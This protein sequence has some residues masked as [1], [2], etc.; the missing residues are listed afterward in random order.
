MAHAAAARDAAPQ[1]AAPPPATTP[2]TPDAAPPPSATAAAPGA[3]PSAA[4]PSASPTT[5]APAATPPHA[6]AGTVVRLEI[7]QAI[8]S[9]IA[10]RGDTFTLRL[11]EPLTVS[12]EELIPTGTTGVGEVID[13]GHPGMGGAPAKLVLAARYLDYKG[14]HIRL[15]SFVVGGAG[16]DNTR[17]SAAVSA[18]PY[19]GL[20]GPFITG[21]NIDIP[22]GTMAD[23][24]LAA[25]F[26]SVPAPAS[27]ATAAKPADQG[28][29][30]K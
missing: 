11:A 1:P 14:E 26:P 16:K 7:T 2:A 24:K 30:P 22:P 6:P 19:A 27:D 12:G 10:K 9:K 20:I 23:A 21:G 5:P 25:D 29:N 17:L 8:S 13:V 28:G 15:R 3:I 4:S 18:V